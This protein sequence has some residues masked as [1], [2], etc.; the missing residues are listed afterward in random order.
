MNPDDSVYS[1]EE[2]EETARLFL[3]LKNHSHCTLSKDQ[4]AELKKRFPA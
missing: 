4:V 2:L 1:A 3:P